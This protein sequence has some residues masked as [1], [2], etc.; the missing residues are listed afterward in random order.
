[1]TRRALPPGYSLSPAARPA[2]F[3]RWRAAEESAGRGATMA[4]AR[5]KA[6]GSAR[7]RGA[8]NRWPP[9][10]SLSPAAR[11]AFF[12]R[13]RAAEES[14]GRGAT[15]ATARRKAT[16]SARQRGADNRWPPGYSLS[17]AA[18]P[19]F[20]IR[21]RAAE[22]SAGR[23]AT[24][25]T[26]RRKATGSA[27]QRGADNRWPPGYS[28]SP[29]ARPAFFIRWRA[30]EESAGRGATMAT[31]RRKATGSARQRGADNRWPPGYSLS[32]AARPAFFIRWRAAEESAGRG[33]TMATA[34]R[35]ATGS[36]R[37]RGADNRWPPGYSLSPAA[38]PAF[39]IRW[40][41]AE[42]SAGRGA[43]MATAR[44]KATGSARQRGA[45]NRWP[46]GYS[47]S[48]AARPA[49][50]IRWRAAEES[51]G[52]GAT[53]ATARRKAT[54]SARQRGADNRWPPGY[55]LSPAARPAF[56]IRWRAAEES[57]GRGATMATARRKAT[58]SA[59]QRGADNRWPP[60]YSLSPAA[61][62]AFFIRWRAAE[63]SAGRGATMATA[64]R[65]AT[66][67]ARQRGADN[68]WLDPWL[69]SL[70]GRSAGILY[71]LAGRRRIC[72]SG[73][74]DGD[75]AAKSYGVSKA[76]RR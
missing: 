57:A 22:E 65:K 7:Q 20:F 67:S 36:A 43:T 50:F 70:S 51:A 13:W 49:F 38:R 59:R 42:E 61:R 68:R 40:R 53:M 46:P 14:A 72:R 26:A 10:Y 69:L 25:A 73:R 76:T 16:G 62:P 39:F 71:P 19:A 24:M 31:A 21:W 52:R 15:M 48:P 44:R 6:T 58:G 47:L 75:G 1:M 17:P 66:G 9:G 45:D 3:I 41:A 55:S 60:G 54:G 28:L 23:G 56:F 5:R 8:D 34:R 11:P 64:R 32:P 74:H 4:T 35:K 27:R 12:I 2:F 18:R 37:Q 30:A 63:E 33:A 29:A